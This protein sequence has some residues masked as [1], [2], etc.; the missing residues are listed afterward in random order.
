MVNPDSIEIIINGGI[1]RPGDQKE[2]SDH[3][4]HNPKPAFLAPTTEIIH[5]FNPFMVMNH[6]PNSPVLH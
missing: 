1:C 5:A 2:Y 4:E 3:K 6:V